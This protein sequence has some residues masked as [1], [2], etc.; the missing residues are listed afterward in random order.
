MTVTFLRHGE[1]DFNKSNLFCGICDCS[2]TEEAKNSASKLK[3]ELPEF[4]Y[5]YCSPLKR[6]QETLKA[7]FPNS[8][9][10]I[11]DR[12]IEI[13]LG[14]WEGLP[15]TSVNQEL[16][17]KFKNGNFSPEGAESNENVEKRVKDFLNNLFATYSSD[18]KV[19][20]VT[21]NGILRTISRLLNINSINNNLEYFTIESSN[22]SYLI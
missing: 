18:E 7:I 11:D 5:Y 13:S 20:I 15:K 17:S 14:I 8:I 6:T 12:I 16:R 9:P 21:H 2:I 1:T 22:Y 19:L 3:K 10:I 4:D